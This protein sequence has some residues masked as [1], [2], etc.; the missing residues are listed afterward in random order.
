MNLLAK[1]F[2]RFS[3]TLKSKLC[4]CLILCISLSFNAYPQSLDFP[5]PRTSVQHK[6]TLSGSSTVISIDANN[7]ISKASR[8]NLGAANFMLTGSNNSNGFWYDKTGTTYNWTTQL[9][10]RLKALEIPLSR[11]YAVY[12]EAGGVYNGL[13]M[14]ANM[15]NRNNI[16]QDKIIVCLEH[17]K[18]SSPSQ[19]LD[20]SVYI[21]AINYCKTQGYGFR[22]WETSNEPPYAKGSGIEKAPAYALHIKEVYDA[23]K[24]AD[25]NAIV[26]C[27]ILRKSVYS[28]DVLT[29]IEGKA[30]FIAGHWYGGMNNMDKY[31]TTEM[32][33]ADNFKYLNY[34]AYENQNIKNRTGK[35][36]PQIDTEWR[37]L[38]GATVNGVYYDGE[39]N[40][41]VGNIVGTLYQAVRLIYNIRD[42]YTQG[43][44]TWHSMGVNPGVLVPAGWNQSYGITLD[45]KTSY[46]Y[47][48]YYY[49]GHNTGENV[50]DFTGSAPSFTGNAFHNVDHGS[51]GDESHTGPLTPLMVTKSKDRTKLYITVVNG[52]TTTTVPFSATISNF[53]I[54]SQD[55]ILISDTDINQTWYQNNNSRFVSNPSISK[56]G[57]QISYSLPPLSCTFIT[58][59]GTS[60][61]TDVPA[62]NNEPNPLSPGFFNKYPKADVAI[63]DI[64]GKLVSKFR[65]SE[66]GWNSLIGN[67]TQTKV[68]FYLIDLNNGTKPLKGKYVVSR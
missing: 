57:N 24:S 53:N 35:V 6:L 37:L 63:Y 1:F 28:D 17:Y 46:L 3:F 51:T 7:L 45:G 9:E 58:L 2:L 52:S 42:S 19:V 54:T 12:F 15:C 11:S 4:I 48:L 40:P 55:A 44:C 47:W 60:E 20:P 49:M 13:N 50:V 23:I 8:D 30:D 61:T 39:T 27:Q 64:T 25:P 21:D 34:I 59:T 10:N 43:S 18:A 36:I 32:I 22:Y 33:L 31:S 26:G 41:R 67:N 29:G 68:F 5:A 66:N 38:A 14:L 65:G 56:D 16:P 62:L